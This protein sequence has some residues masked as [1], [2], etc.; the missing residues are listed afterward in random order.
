MQVSHSVPCLF[1]HQ[2]IILVCIFKLSSS[3]VRV[4]V[5]MN[6]H[7]CPSRHSSQ[8]APKR[9]ILKSNAETKHTR[10]QRQDSSRDQSNFFWSSEPR[11]LEPTTVHESIFLRSLISRMSVGILRETHSYLF[12]KVSRTLA[13]NCGYFVQRLNFLKELSKYNVN[14]FDSVRCSRTAK[15]ER[16]FFVFV[17]ALVW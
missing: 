5:S 4:V 14:F 15:L 8:G 16:M 17:Y 9:G 3:K 12:S 10:L 2:C 6:K 11:V 7:G 1:L 13:L